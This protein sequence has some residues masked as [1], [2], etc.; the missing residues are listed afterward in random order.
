MYN[1]LYRF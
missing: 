1:Q